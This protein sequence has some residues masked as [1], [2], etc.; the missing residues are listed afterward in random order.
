M[1]VLIGALDDPD[2]FLR[3]KVVA[4]LEKLRRDHPRLHI[5]RGSIEALVLKEGSRYCN[6][7]TLRYNLLQRDADSRRSLL[8]RALEEK[9]GR[10]LDRTYR[11][12]GL[13][14]PWKDVAAARYTIEHQTGRSRAGAIEYLDNLLSGAI[15]KRIMPII[16]DLSMEEKV[17]HANIVLKSRPR[18]ETVFLRRTTALSSRSLAVND[19]SSFS[20][21]APLGKKRLVE[22]LP[23]G[24]ETA[25]AVRGHASTRASGRTS[26]V[27]ARSWR[28]GPWSARS[29]GLCDQLHTKGF[30]DPVHRVKAWMRVG[31]HTYRESLG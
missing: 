1:D 25:S 28:A 31:P 13:I 9:L 27:A 5:P 15:R 26:P 19:R 7:L 6:Y 12:L 29:D 3:Y 8:A 16:E 21:R 24:Y 22:T 30:A 11:L 18:G 4:A 14:Y 20:S 2:G 10:T 17:R 23:I